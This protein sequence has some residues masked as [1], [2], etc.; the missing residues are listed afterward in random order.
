MD[1]KIGARLHNRFDIEV[2]DILSGEIVKRAQAENIVLNGVYNI[3]ASSY[4]NL[5]ANRINFG[6]G[7]GTF[8]PTRTTLFNHSGYYS[9]SL[10]ESVYNAPPLASY[11]K[12]KIVIPP[13]D[14]VGVTITEVGLGTDGTLISHAMLEDSEGNP[15]SIGPK[16]DTQ[17][18]TIYATLYV[19]LNFPSGIDALLHSTF[20][21]ALVDA[22]LG[23]TTNGMGIAFYEISSTNR[24]SFTKL[25]AST[26]KAATV[27]TTAYNSGVILTSSHFS[28]FDIPNKRSKTNRLRYGT[29]VANQK[30]WSLAWYTEYS[31]ARPL[32]RTVF[33]NQFWEGY[34]FVGKAIGTGNGSTVAFNL[35][36]SDINTTK[37]YKIYLDGVEKTQGVDYTL[38][39]SES[40][41]TVTFTTAPSNGAAITGDWWVD[42]IP[43]DSDHV[44][45]VTLTIQYGSV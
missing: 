24:A 29:S 2:K 41:T 20:K 38:S 37:T 43:K 10:V 15:I 44:L 7:S 35:P 21:N 45:D 13:Q 9:A 25:Y 30:I 11:A 40:T 3:L 16:T 19:E 28:V 18:I 5:M 22:M 8:A 42:Y 6:S 23:L 32:F 1:I 33:P 4:S 39:N 34:N 31:G 14:H 12:K 26:N 17:E 27:V 36:W